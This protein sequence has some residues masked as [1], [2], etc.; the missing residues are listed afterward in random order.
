MPQSCYKSYYYY[1]QAC[2]F[3]GTELRDAGEAAADC[4]VN[5]DGRLAVFVNKDELNS[6]KKTMTSTP[7][8]WIGQFIKQLD[9]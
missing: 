7:T 9:V 6:L 5:H 4:A 2:Y 1:R 3:L 8:A